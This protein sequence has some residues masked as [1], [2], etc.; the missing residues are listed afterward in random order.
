MTSTWTTPAG[1]LPV[2]DRD[3][4]RTRKPRAGSVG[5]SEPGGGRKTFPVGGG[6]AE[7]QA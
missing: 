1:Y 3:A 6:G 5:G 4:S 7:D 2:P